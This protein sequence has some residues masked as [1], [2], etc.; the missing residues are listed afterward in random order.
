MIGVKYAEPFLLKTAIGI[1]DPLAFFRANPV[2]E[3]L[4]SPELP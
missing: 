4:G 2:N 3:P 1:G